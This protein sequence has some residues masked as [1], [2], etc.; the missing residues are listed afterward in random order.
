MQV[1]FSVITKDKLPLEK[2]CTISLFPI[3]CSCAVLCFKQL[4]ACLSFFSFLFFFQTLPTQIITSV[5]LVRNGCIHNCNINLRIFLTHM[6]HLF[7]KL[8]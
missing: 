4:I 1:A 6:F 8:Q 5:D 3:L 2:K 7:E